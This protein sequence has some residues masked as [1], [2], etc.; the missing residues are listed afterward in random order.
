MKGCDCM[1]GRGASSGAGK[2]T[3]TGLFGANC[4]HTY[5]PFFKGYHKE[6]ILMSN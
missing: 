2:G 4:Y 5:Y 6:L 3:V 1:G